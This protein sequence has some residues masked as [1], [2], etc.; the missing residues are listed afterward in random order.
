[1]TTITIFSEQDRLTGFSVA[2]HSG[3][4]EAGEDIVCAAITSAVR[5]V[6]CTLNEVMGLEVSVK[7]KEKD[8]SIRLQL[9]DKLGSTHEAMCQ[10]ILTGFMVYLAELAEEYPQYVLVL[11]MEV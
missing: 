7:V 1:M 2:G 4:A 3:Y 9:P 6:E 5:Q 11:N 8:A 10:T